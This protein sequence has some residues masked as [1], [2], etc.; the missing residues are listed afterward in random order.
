[1]RPIRLP[2]LGCGGVPEGGDAAEGFV[3]RYGP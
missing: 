1:L 2:E 3:R